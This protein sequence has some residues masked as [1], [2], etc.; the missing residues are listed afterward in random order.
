MAFDQQGLVF[1]VR[2]DKRLIKLYDAN[3]YD[4]G[5]FEN[6]VVSLPSV[7][8]CVCVCVVSLIHISET[9]RHQ[10]TTRMPSCA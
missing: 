1:A 3:Q 8:V 5:P 10:H 2:L 6:F 4:Q 7:C 9:T